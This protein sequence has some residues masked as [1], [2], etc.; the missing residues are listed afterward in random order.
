MNE[1]DNLTPLIE[2][3]GI[4]KYFGPVRA[5]ENINLVIRH[6]EVL[7][8]VGDNGAGKSTLMKILTGAHQ[9]TSGEILFEG[10]PVHFASPHES[11]LAG[12][13]MVYQDLALAGNLSVASNIYL[14]REPV[15]RQWGVFRFMDE[16]RIE[17]GSRELLDR[18]KINIPN[19]KARVENL[20]GGQRQSVA[21]ARATAFNA[22][23]VIMDEP[24]AALAVKE[25]AKVL[26]T[27][28][29]LRAHGV[30]VVLISH[31]M[32][33]VMSVAE[34]IIV[35]YEGTKVADLERSKTTMDEVV[36]YIV[37]SKGNFAEARA[38]AEE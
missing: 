17:S 38:A 31:R 11:R 25:V 22:K 5:L 8:L 18:L 2:L 28:R 12:I 23:L 10:K 4:S 3:R 33:D 13:E 9:P 30:A 19:V 1:R 20:S 16:K 24:T 37:G 21:I 15:K 35:L 34:R 36:A 14:G 7:G 32:Q 27:V 29:N 6:D 26:E